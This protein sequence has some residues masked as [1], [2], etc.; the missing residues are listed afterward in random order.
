MINIG[1]QNNLVKFIYHSVLSIE[2]KQKLDEQLSDP[3]N[4]TYRKNKTIVKVFLKRKP[5]QVLAYLR[6]ESG[7]FVIKGYKFG[8]SDYL[9]GRK[10][11]HFKTVESIFLIDKE[12]RE[13]RY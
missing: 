11:S 2:S 12:E 7:K 1:F 13:K 5:Q 8:K 4:S 9:T 6:F 3:I 10:K